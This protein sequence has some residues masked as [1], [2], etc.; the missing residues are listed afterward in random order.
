MLKPDKPAILN[1]SGLKH[2][3][4]LLHILPQLKTL[5]LKKLK[6][7]SRKSIMAPN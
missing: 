1:D 7:A 6:A 2:A 3:I 4:E 5:V